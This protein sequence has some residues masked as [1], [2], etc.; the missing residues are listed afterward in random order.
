MYGST[1]E[2]ND[3]IP[4]NVKDKKNNT[5]KIAFIPGISLM[6]DGNATNAN[7][8]PTDTTLSIG[9]PLCKAMNPSAANTPI[10]ANNSKLEFANPVINALF[11]TSDFLG[12]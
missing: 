7:P 1:M 12:K 4:A 2:I 8:T 5:P 11:V 6:I 3:E 10:P 9:K